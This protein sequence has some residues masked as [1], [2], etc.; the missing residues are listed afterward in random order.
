MFF[1]D[2]SS[3]HGNCT[4]AHTYLAQVKKIML[5]PLQAVENLPSTSI[6]FKL[7]YR[8]FLKGSKEKR[9]KADGWQ[10]T[11]INILVNA[12]V[13]RLQTQA[14]IFISISIYKLYLYLYSYIAIYLSIYLNINPNQCCPLNHPN[15]SKILVAHSSDFISATQL[16]S[17]QILTDQHEYNQNQAHH[18]SSAP[19]YASFLERFALK[20]A[21]T[22][23]CTT[24]PPYIAK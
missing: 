18:S 10:N 24:W 12:F 8:W 7:T 19:K 11:G 4:A 15:Y 17:N 16:D 20:S 3:Q 21:N 13:L 6:L 14:S 1:S 5:L 22:L 9:R 2:P 23:L